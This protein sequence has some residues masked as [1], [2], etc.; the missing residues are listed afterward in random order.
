[1]VPSREYFNLPIQHTA[2][3]GA[4]APSSMPLHSVL[5]QPGLFDP[6]ATARDGDYGASANVNRATAGDLRGR[7]AS[8][9]TSSRWSSAPESRLPSSPTSTKST[10]GC[11]WWWTK[12]YPLAV[13][14]RERSG[15]GSSAHLSSAVPLTA[16]TAPIPGGAFTIRQQRRIWLGRSISCMAMAA[17]VVSTVPAALHILRLEKIVPFEEVIM[18]HIDGFR[19]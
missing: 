15:S 7:G 3:R 2:A 19:V 17:C 14:A 12:Q 9:P 18:G 5:V 11:G 16:M 8:L 6:N 13:A 1:M 10:S 4:L